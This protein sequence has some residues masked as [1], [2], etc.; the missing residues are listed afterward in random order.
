MVRREYTQLEHQLKWAEK[1]GTSLA[2]LI[3]DI[4]HFKKVNDKYGHL[5][6][7]HVLAE[8]AQLAKGLV[9]KNDILAR[10]GGEEFVLIAPNTG[11]KGAYKLGE[12]IRRAVE[13]HT[14]Q[15]EGEKMS[16]TVSIG[17]AVLDESNDDQQ[18]LQEEL[19]KAADEALYLAKN[20]GRNRVEISSKRE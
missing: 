8:L 19:I 3:F 11:E 1:R 20:K 6:G 7:D 15:Y 12:R 10:F 16:V 17:I 9:R 18:K 13:S 4:D 14:F 5:A 2:L